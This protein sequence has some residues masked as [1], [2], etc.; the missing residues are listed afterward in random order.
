MPHHLEIGVVGL[1]VVFAARAVCHRANVPG[2]GQVFQRAVRKKKR[3][4]FI[5]RDRQGLAVRD[6]A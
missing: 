1:Q 4:E 5:R 6:I 2:A 3:R